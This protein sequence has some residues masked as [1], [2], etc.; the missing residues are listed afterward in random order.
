MACCSSH[1]P[2]DSSS[3]ASR[4]S[5]RSIASTREKLRRTRSCPELD[6]WP[7]FLEHCASV[8][9]PV[10]VHPWDMANPENRLSRYMMGCK[11]ETH[12]RRSIIT[13][14]SLATLAC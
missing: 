8:D 1:L 11:R 5:R 12:T 14:L 6:R 13:A 9:A 4:P 3:S 7:A 2:L 10:L